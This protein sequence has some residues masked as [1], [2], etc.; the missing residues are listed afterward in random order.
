MVAI[1]IVISSLLRARNFNTKYSYKGNQSLFC[2]TM[3][4]AS[5]QLVTI[6]MREFV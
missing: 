2:I 4:I 3:L 5:S 1:V 6:V